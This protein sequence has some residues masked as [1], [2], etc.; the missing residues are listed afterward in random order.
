MAN[1]YKNKVVYNG[2]TLIDIS[3][4][5][6]VQSDVASGK[7][8]YTASGQKV[9]GTASGGSGGTGQTATGTVTGDG[10]NVLE[11]PC[12]F[13]P[14]L[15]YVYGDMS[16]DVANRGITSLTIIKDNSIYVGADT[17]ASSIQEY[18]TSIHGITGYNESD[19]SNIHATYSNGTLTINTMSGSSSGRWRSGQVYNYELSTIGTG[20]GSSSP[21]LVTKE[22]TSNG[23][24]T[25]SNDSA[26]GYSSV[27]VNVP[28]SGITP[29]GSINITTNGTHDVTNYASAVVSVSGSG[30]PSAT[31]HTIH[32]D[33]SDETDTDID[34]Y[35]D[36]ALLATMIQEYTP[37][38]YGQKT[39]ILAQLDG[40]TWYEPT[41]I[42]LNTQ[43]IDYNAVLTGYTISN[44]GNVTASDA[45][46]CVTDYT[47]I[48]PTM[49]FSFKCEQYALIGFYNTQKN[50]IRTVE[51]NNIKDSAEDYVA[52]GYLTPSII[53]LGTAY[54]VLRGNSYGI[55]N[56]LSLIRTA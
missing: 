3:D 8:F 13:E 41:S 44:D 53:P 25:A 48:D 14:D 54:V 16:S 34:V 11:I 7:F 1:Q 50:P 2:T 27:T 45:W 37:A 56:T 22:I 18:V 42:P 4:T 38:T 35:Y 21:T 15:I 46:N 6:A 26:D 55:E 24:Y 52:S 10:T 9:L 39:V 31:K 23:T 12:N 20:S 29:T 32:F 28:S 19:A 5:T 51:A 33:F 36:D 17:S 49:T 47:P 30:T 40:V 43:L